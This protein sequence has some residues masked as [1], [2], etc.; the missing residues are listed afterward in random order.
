MTPSQR[1]NVAVALVVPVGRRYSIVAQSQ[2]RRESLPRLV[3]QVVPDPLFGQAPTVYQGAAVLLPLLVWAAARRRRRVS[4]AMGLA[5]T[6]ALAAGVG[7][8]STG[9]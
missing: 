4:L 6:A 5:C 3:R 8:H 7:A 1:V 2:S 9:G